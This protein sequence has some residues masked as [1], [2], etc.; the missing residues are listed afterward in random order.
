MFLPELREVR[1][2]LGVVNSSGV[3]GEN[4][5]RGDPTVAF[6][7]N[8]LIRTVHPSAAQRFSLEVPIDGD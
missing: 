8:R 2:Q 7:D 4:Q 5:T 1:R 3:T 6:N